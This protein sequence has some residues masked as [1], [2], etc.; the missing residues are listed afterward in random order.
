MTKSIDDQINQK[1]ANLNLCKELWEIYH[2]TDAKEFIP[3]LEEELKE[4]EERQI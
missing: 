1:K 4:L 3:K 2:D